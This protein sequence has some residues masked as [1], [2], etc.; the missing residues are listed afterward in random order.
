V[1]SP[2]VTERSAGVAAYGPVDQQV[3][4]AVQAADPSVDRVEPHV[5]RVEAGC[6]GLA[7]IAGRLGG[8][9]RQ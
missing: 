5:H 9:L 8:L 3:Y 4:V 7:S 6:R 2:K 1:Q